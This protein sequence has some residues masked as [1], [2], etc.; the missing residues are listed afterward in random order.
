[1]KGRVDSDRDSPNENVYHLL[2]LWKRA[3]TSV[4]EAVAKEVPHR[5]R[6]VVL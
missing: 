3:E 1:M 5:L 4:R 6:Q 2:T